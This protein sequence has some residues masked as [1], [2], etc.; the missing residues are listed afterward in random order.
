MRT[1]EAA[2]FASGLSET[3]LQER[4]GR[5]V[6]DEVGGSLLQGQRAAI[7]VGHG[8][9]GRDGAIAAE[10]LATRGV[11]VDLILAPRHTVTDDELLRLRT[12]GASLIPIGGDQRR[13]QAALEGATLVVDAVAG[14]G[15]HGALR[16]PLASM[17]R[18]INAVKHQH[19]VA[20]DVPS[21]IDADTGQVEGEAVWAHTTVTLGAVKQGLL[22]FPAAER[23]GRL[24]V[25]DIGIPAAATQGLA[26]RCLAPQDVAAPPR[27]LD[28][29]KYRFGRVLV[30]AGS[31]HFLGAPL[32]C[33]GGA[34]R[35]GAGLVSVAT[36]PAARQALAT[37]F[38]EATYPPREL[39]IEADP[40]AAA[41][42]LMAYESSVLVVGPGL[43]RSAATTAFV[44]ELL[45]VRPPGVSLVLDADAL[46][47][48]SELPEWHTRL[49][50]NTILTPHGGELR[51]LA[52]V[53]QGDAAA[54]VAA[55]QLA[56][57]W[58]CVLVAKGPFTS[59]ATPDG[60][61]DVWPHANAALA[62]GGTGDVLAG[63]CGGLLAQGCAPDAAARLAVV[64]HAQAAQQVVQGRAW[65]T[66]LASD[67]L[68]ALPAILGG[69]TRRQ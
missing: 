5:V 45:R 51:R 55:G 7:M 22:Q 61:V 15:T 59:V 14:I 32:L 17:A 29:H 58:G 30:V 65:R 28:A 19:V 64:A 25:R 40:G 21:G 69:L 10:V 2:A 62:T 36:P 54:W 18:S 9:N 12:L 4:A 60:R 56:A 68:D 33:A 52:G 35:A 49:G 38:P 39:R 34:L 46:F 20:L 44:D 37:R 50:P 6:A 53:Q 24:V 43:G 31:E 66:L 11:G 3:L 1:L 26:Y 13:A 57:Q 8:N 63:L 16:E 47:A 23:V 67:L 41:R 27:P 48:L 42:Q